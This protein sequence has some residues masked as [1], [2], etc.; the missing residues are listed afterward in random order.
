MQTQIQVL[1][2]TLLSSLSPRVGW[3]K[4]SLFGKE[5]E[6]S[7]FDE[8]AV[9]AG[10]DLGFIPQS[11]DSDHTR[12]GYAKPHFS[13]TVYEQVGLEKGILYQDNQDVLSDYNAT[14]YGEQIVR[15]LAL[16]APEVRE[17]IQAEA[18]SIAC[19]DIHS[20]LISFSEIVT[21]MWSKHEEFMTVFCAAIDWKLVSQH[22]KAGLRTENK[23]VEKL[24]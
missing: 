3:A 15:R 14:E 11:E 22:K 21:E 2:Y 18:T 6:F 20:S 8:D 7:F 23:I 4:V 24:L 10:I 17:V 12:V 5:V 9:V 1:D 16:Q 19:C 13:A